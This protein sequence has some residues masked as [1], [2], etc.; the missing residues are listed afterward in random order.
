M[1][2]L[3]DYFKNRKKRWSASLKGP[4]LYVPQGYYAQITP[5]AH[6]YQYIATSGIATCCALYI[7]CPHTKQSIL[8]H[9]DE[10]HDLALLIDALKISILSPLQETD[11]HLFCSNSYESKALAHTVRGMLVEA[12]VSIHQTLSDIAFSLKNGK[13]T[14]Y[15]EF[16]I[17]GMDLENSEHVLLQRIPLTSSQPVLMASPS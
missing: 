7:F 8:A 3:S 2:S 10:T 11:I 9:I 14:E 4:R 5:Q 13:M 1:L 15:R 12:D 6:G 17:Q 16:N